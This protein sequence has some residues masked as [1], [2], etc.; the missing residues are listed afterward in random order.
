MDFHAALPITRERLLRGK[1]DAIA[2]LL[3]NIPDVQRVASA[4]PTSRRVKA[5]VDLR[6]SRRT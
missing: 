2:E 6:L 4:L 3:E 1:W 5:L